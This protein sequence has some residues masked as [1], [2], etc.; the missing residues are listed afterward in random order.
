MKPKRCDSA[1]HKIKDAGGW[2]NVQHCI[3]CGKIVNNKAR[4]YPYC[5]RRHQEGK[6]WGYNF[7]PDCGAKL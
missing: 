2:V 6:S 3:K 5:K 1:L 4:V 7:C